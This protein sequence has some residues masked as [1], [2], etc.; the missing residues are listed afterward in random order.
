MDEGQ[1]CCSL[2][3][4]GLA[5]AGDRALRKE[6][7]QRE[8]DVVEGG[9]CGYEPEGRFTAPAVRNVVG[10]EMGWELLGQCE[11]AVGS[12]EDYEQ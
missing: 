2:L 11:A 6:S 9:D 8:K 10:V 1:G 4:A 12:N 5:E 7:D 3:W